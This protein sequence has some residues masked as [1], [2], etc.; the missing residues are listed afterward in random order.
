MSFKIFSYFLHFLYFLFSYNFHFYSSSYIP[1]SIVPQQFLPI[2]T[3]NY[4]NIQKLFMWKKSFNIYDKIIH[5]MN[6]KKNEIFDRRL[7]QKQQKFT[8]K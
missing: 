2:P 6:H 1:K 8:H 7:M 4:V 5:W 3:Q